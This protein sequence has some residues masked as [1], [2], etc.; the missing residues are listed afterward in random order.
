MQLKYL[1][2]TSEYHGGY[3]AGSGSIDTKIYECP[4]EK[5]KVYRIKD[6]IPGFRDSEIDCDCS[7]CKAKY[8]FG[9]GTA[10]ER[11]IEKGKFEQC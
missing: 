1:D 4:C 11:G 10:T 8:E 7:G 2:S 9:R 3:D 5:G 6:S